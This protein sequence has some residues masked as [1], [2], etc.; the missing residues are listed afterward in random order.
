MNGAYSI[1]FQQVIVLARQLSAADKLRL[2][3]QLAPEIAREL[4]PAA[5][6][7]SLWGSCADLGP[8]PAAEE[9]DA[10]R[11]ELWATFPREDF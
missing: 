1:A 9:I 6:Q 8:A 5:P 7:Q 11:R 3:E 10:A 4:R 2:I